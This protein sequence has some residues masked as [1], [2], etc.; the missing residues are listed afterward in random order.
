MITWKNEYFFEIGFSFYLILILLHM[1]E[2][3]ND[4]QPAVFGQNV[5]PQ[6]SRSVTVGITWIP[7]SVIGSFVEWQPVSFLSVQLGTHKYL[8]LIYGKMNKRSFF[9][10]EK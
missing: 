1:N 7:F 6:I 2:I 10:V 5:F 4:F 3:F 9:E 8:I